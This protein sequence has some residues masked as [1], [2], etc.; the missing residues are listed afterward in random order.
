MTRIP[1]PKPSFLDQQEVWKIV[2]GKKVYRSPDGSKLY[3]WDSFHGEIE[4][5]NK[6]GRHLG[7]L[8]AITGIMIKKAVRGRTIDV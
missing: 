4:V 7:V 8:D 6:Q 1:L 2:G 5:Y 3:Q